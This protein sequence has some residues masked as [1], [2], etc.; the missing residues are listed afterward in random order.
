MKRE[1]TVSEAKVLS[2]IRNYRNEHGYSPTMQEIGDAL[3]VCRVTVWEHAHGLIAKGYLRQ[4]GNMNRALVPVGE[5]PLARC[6]RLTQAMK[7]IIGYTRL[8]DPAEGCRNAL[9]EAEDALQEKG[10][11]RLDRR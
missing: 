3:G 7:R 9:A 5:D 8:P 2:C 1:P 6:A 10:R 11:Q 4:R